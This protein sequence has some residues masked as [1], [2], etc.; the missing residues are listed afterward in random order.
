MGGESA[1]SS[2]ATAIRSPDLDR[3]DLWGQLCE[4]AKQD[5]FRRRELRVVTR[6]SQ[7]R[8]AKLVPKLIAP[9]P[10]PTPTRTA[11]V[12]ESSKPMPS[13]ALAQALHITQEGMTAFQ[14]LQEQTAQLHRQFLQNQ[15][16]AQQTLN[17]MIE[18]QQQL[19]LSSL[20]VSA[21]VQTTPPPLAALSAARAGD[22]PIACKA[23]G[24]KGAS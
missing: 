16:I 14:R 11:T 3:A 18:Q 7:T 23:A 5:R 10:S 20:G 2:A 1:A 8:A 24:G 6:F 12:N 9:T 13:G 17:R 15:E 19:I 4:T 22:I 21:P